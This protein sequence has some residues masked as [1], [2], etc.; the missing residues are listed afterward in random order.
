MQ[1]PQPPQGLQQPG[2]YPPQYSRP[3]FGLPLSALRSHPRLA[4]VLSLITV[5]AIIL[6][7]YFAF[8][9]PRI[10]L[11]MPS[12]SH[13]MHCYVN[14]CVIW[15]GG[16]LSN[17]GSAD[18]YATVNWVLNGNVTQQVRYLVPAQDAYGINLVQ[19]WPEGNSVPDPSSG[20]QLISVQ[21]A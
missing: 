2:Q 16:I 14:G 12:P 11:S 6:L 10:T 17:Y 15:V 13:G 9:Q 8:F 18:G 5:A 19:P 21:K 1:S 7:Y 4:T 3:Y 20:L